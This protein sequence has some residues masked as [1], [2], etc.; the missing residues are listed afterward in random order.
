VADDNFDHI[1]G[2]NICHEN[3]GVT[4]EK[5]D[6]TRGGF[7]DCHSKS[8]FDSNKDGALNTLYK[9]DDM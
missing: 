4:L 3:G 5:S 7:K 6:T 1:F 8:L 2:T 9:Y